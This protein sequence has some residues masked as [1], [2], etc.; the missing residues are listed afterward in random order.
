MR[1]DARKLDRLPHTDGRR[2]Q[3]AAHGT[4]P[5]RGQSERVLWLKRGLARRVPHR[6]LAPP[7]ERARHPR[8]AL[9]RPHEAPAIGHDLR[10]WVADAEA[11]WGGPEARPGSR[12]YPGTH[13]I[14]LDTTDGL[15]V[16]P[17]LSLDRL[18]KLYS[19]HYIMPP[20]AAIVMVGLAGFLFRCFRD[21]SFRHIIRPAMEAHLARRSGRSWRDR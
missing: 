1:I 3:S 12:V 17:S 5:I 2:M 7:R 6:S 21:A 16:V 10:R 20:R 14:I 13:K 8:E 11:A 18:Q 15:S 4:K 9:R 19:R